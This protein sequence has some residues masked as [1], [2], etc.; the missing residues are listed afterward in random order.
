MGQFSSATFTGADGLELSTSDAAWTKHSSYTGECKLIDNRVRQSTSTAACY[1]H[2]GVPASADYSVEADFFTKETGGGLSYGG[3]AGRIDTS[4]NTMYFARHNPVSGWQLMKA[5]AGTFSQ[6]GPSVATSLT[7]ETTYHIRLEMIRIPETSN[8]AIKVYLN[9][10]GT[11]IISQT[12]GSITAAGKAGLRVGSSGAPSD[13]TEIHFD[14]FSGDD[15]ATG[16]TL[17]PDAGAIAISG[18]APT[19]S[20]PLSLSPAAGAITITGNIPGISQPLSLSPVGGS[21]YLSGNTPTISQPRTLSPGAGAIVVSG[22]VPSI[23]QNTSLSPV[24]GS[25]SITGYAPTISQPRTLSPGAGAITIAG[26][27]PTISQSTS[28]SPGT[29][30]ITLSGYAPTI[31]QPR[32]LSPGAGAITIAGNVPTISQN[33]SL[34]PGTGSITLSGYAPTISQPRTLSPGAGAITITGNIPAISQSTGAISIS[35]FTGSISIT[36]FSP[37]ISQPGAP[38]QLQI[39]NALKTLLVAGSTAAGARVFL[40]R[41]DPLQADELPALV[42]EEAGPITMETIMMDGSER[43]DMDVIVYCALAASD[44]AAADSMTFGLATEKLIAADTGLQTLCQFG[45]N[46]LERSNP[47]NGE[48]DRFLAASQ[49]KW[50]FGYWVHPLNPDVINPL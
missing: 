2:S 3:I 25:I 40:H 47:M 30:S 15:A 44:T 5:D 28:L 45:V 26:N 18:H 33:T 24:G 19:I 22:G 31:S 35:P 41:T 23:A 49:Q 20:Q 34:S 36:G 13:S 32:T 8:S 16:I 29:G 17:S 43:R 7:D 46:I 1:Y 12:D 38:A 48:G 10:S 39:L 14:N 21:I 4:A 11:P 42:I 9:G 50:R 37:S 27:V 6:I